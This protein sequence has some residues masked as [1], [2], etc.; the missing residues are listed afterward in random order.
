MH[1]GVHDVTTAEIEVFL[2][3]DKYIVTK[4]DIKLPELKSVYVLY[5]LEDQGLPINS[6][7]LSRTG[8]A[9]R[10]EIMIFRRQMHGSRLVNCR[11]G[12]DE[13]SAKIARW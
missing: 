1:H 6:T 12:D 9:F 8:E 11:T 7:L 4:L 13:K 5:W 2:D 3:T 10:G